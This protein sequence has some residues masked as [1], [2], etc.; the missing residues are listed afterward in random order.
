MALSSEELTKLFPFDEQKLIEIWKR[1]ADM[2]KEGPEIPLMC[3][4]LFCGA[5]SAG[6]RSGEIRGASRRNPAAMI[7]LTRLP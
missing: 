6:L 2:R 5:V 4:I 1:P 3:G 7:D